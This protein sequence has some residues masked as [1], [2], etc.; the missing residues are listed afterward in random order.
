MKANFL[1]L[2]VDLNGGYKY[3]GPSKQR[4]H[5]FRKHRF[6][7][8][9]REDPVLVLV[10]VPVSGYGS[11][12][13]CNTICARSSYCYSQCNTFSIAV[14]GSSAERVHHL[15]QAFTTLAQEVQKATDSLLL[16]IMKNTAVCM[17]NFCSRASQFTFWP[18]SW[19]YCF[20]QWDWHQFFK[21]IQG[22]IW[23]LS[24]AKCTQYSL[25]TASLRGT[26]VL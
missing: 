16:K 26:A 23:V 10:P 14:T 5:W 8:Q 2:T 7:A 9:F 25:M 12:H 11:S 4:R 3:K 6:L 21:E 1:V 17:F 22:T 20:G 19:C 24:Y 18:E 15:M 13:S